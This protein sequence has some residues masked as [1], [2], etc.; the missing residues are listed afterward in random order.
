MR[1]S[2]I[3]AIGRNREL[4]VKSTNDLPWHIP[5]DMRY[6]R[7]MTRGHTV[8]MGER[9]F[10]SLGKPLPNR[11]NIVL[12]NDESFHPEGVMVARNSEEALKMAR[13]ME[14]E[15][16]FVIGGSMIYSLFLEKS[17]RL[18]LTLVDA[19]F[20]DA[21]VFFPSYK[22]IFTK[23]ISEKKS[24]DKHFRYMFVVLEKR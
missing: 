5:E 24:S 6:F 17:D 19:E 2:I 14:K 1:I 13:D 21:D 7:D 12:S 3:A 4:G 10:Q 18:Y 20:P 11:K 23:V 9:T 22:E 15:E 8:I 16:V